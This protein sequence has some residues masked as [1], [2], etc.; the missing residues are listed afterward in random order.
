MTQGIGVHGGGAAGRSG[1]RWLRW[2]WSPALPLLLVGACTAV[3]SVDEYTHTADRDQLVGIWVNDAGTRIELRADSTFTV[4]GIRLA[5]G[6]DHGNRPDEPDGS[7]TWTWTTRYMDTD[8]VELDFSDGRSC[9]RPGERQDCASRFTEL[10]A[11]REH[12]RGPAE[13]A[14]ESGDPDSPDVVPFHR[15]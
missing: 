14:F 4:T 5:P 10:V 7:G 6:P 12:R 13:L 2:A 8:L 15:P 11:W 1:R 3:Q 9:R